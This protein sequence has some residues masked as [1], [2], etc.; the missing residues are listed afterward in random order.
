MVAGTFLSVAGCASEACLALGRGRGTLGRGAGDPHPSHHR[1]LSN[2]RPRALSVDERELSPE[3]RR[4]T[5]ETGGASEIKWVGLQ[6][7]SGD[8][9]LH[10]RLSALDTRAFRA[11][12]KEKNEVPQSGK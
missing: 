11:P 4:A 3:V 1:V 12:Q 10:S 2:P 6:G 8:F 5:G 7:A 9:S